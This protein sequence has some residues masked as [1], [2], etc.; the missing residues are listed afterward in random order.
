MRGLDEKNQTICFDNRFHLLPLRNKLAPKSADNLECFD[1]RR[2]QTPGHVNVN[3]CYLKL[4]LDEAKPERSCSTYAPFNWWISLVSLLPHRLLCIRNNRKMPEKCV[5]FCASTYN[6]CDLWLLTFCRRVHK[7]TSVWEC[8]LEAWHL[9]RKHIRALALKSFFCSCV[10]RARST[11]DDDLFNSIQ[12]RIDS[13]Q[14]QIELVS[15]F[16]DLLVL[17][18]ASSIH[19]YSFS[20]WHPSE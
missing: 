16:I 9:S 3:N 2:T 19:P 5:F 7:S 10:I 17:S 15:I 6:R 14:F 8:L 12:F 4:K 11:H 13:I 1:Y 20:S 18:R